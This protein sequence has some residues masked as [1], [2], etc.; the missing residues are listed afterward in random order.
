MRTREH[1]FTMIE[2]MVAVGILTV[3][4]AG[5]MESFVVQNRAYTVVDQT[6]ESQQNLRALSHLLERDLRMTGFMV[7]EGAVVCGIDFTDRPDVLYVTDSDPIDPENQPS[8]GLGARVTGYTGSVGTTVSLALPDG[9]VLDGNDANAL[10][11]D[12]YYDTN[13]DGIGD[14]DFREAGGVILFDPSNPGRGT[15]CGTVIDVASSTSLRVEFENTIGGAGGDFRLVP[16]IRYTVNVDGELLRNDVTLATDID[17]FQVAYFIDADGN[18]SYDTTP[19]EYQ[20]SYDAGDEYE[21]RNTDHSDLREIRFNLVMRARAEDER[22]ID[23]FQQATENRAAA[24]ATDG[25]RR[26]LLTT[27]VRPRNI[28]F[29]GPQA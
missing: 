19:S 27:T 4:V 10:D 22:Y 28:G 11:V 5:V 21:S 26:R 2:M 23:G 13:N 25:F 9:L 24:G 29:R 3:V 8:A 15:A 1:G 14:S 12:G 20:G 18:G 17:D 6:T 7:A 16:A